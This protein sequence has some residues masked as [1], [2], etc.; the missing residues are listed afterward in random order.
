MPFLGVIDL[1]APAEVA[2]L[3]DIVLA[4]QEVLG[5]YVS[6]DKPV[7]VQEVNTS[8][9]LDKEVEGLIFCQRLLLPDEVEEVAL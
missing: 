2:N 8:T 1:D 6:M 7:L 3:E 4:N 5:L 9:S